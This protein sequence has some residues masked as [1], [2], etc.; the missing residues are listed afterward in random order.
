MTESRR[1]Q[2]VGVMCLTVTAVMLAEPVIALAEPIGTDTANR[3]IVRSAK[4]PV[5]CW[6]F[7]WLVVLARPDPRTGVNFVPRFDWSLG[8]VLCWV[9]IAVAFHLGHGWSHELAWEHTRQVG[10]FGD[11]IFVNYM[12]A[13][14]WLADVLWAWVAFDSYLA[15]PGWLK[16]TI[17]G[18]IAFVVV[19]AAVVFGTWSSRGTFFAFFLGIL[20]GV[21][22]VKR[23]ERRP[24]T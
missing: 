18:F 6:C 2:L 22:V 3:A 9:H 24:L 12:F 21:V 20:A 11:G 4:W 5:F 19:N 17:H 10:G 1:V 7:G 23:R 14:V 16:W 13:L 8:C 15:R